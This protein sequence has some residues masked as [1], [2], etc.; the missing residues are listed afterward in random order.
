MSVDGSRT[1]GHTPGVLDRTREEANFFWSDI[2][3]VRSDL[4]ALAAKEIELLRAR[5]T[6]RRASLCGC[7]FSRQPLHWPRTHLRR[8]RFRHA[9]VRAGLLDGYLAGRAH[10]YAR[11][12]RPGRDCQ[13]TRLPVFKKF[14]PVPKRSNIES[15]KEDGQW[16]RDLMTSTRNKANPQTD[17][18]ADRGDTPARKG[19]RAGV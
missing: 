2:A 15:V 7:S 17:L 13:F 8:F 14:S 19:R 12:R 5:S 3:A 11:R 18:R 1:N 6:N 10:N 16:A 4:Q 9:H